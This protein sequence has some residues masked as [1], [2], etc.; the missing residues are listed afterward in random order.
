MPTDTIDSYYVSA[1]IAKHHGT[2]WTRPET[3]EF[4]HLNA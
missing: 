1:H 3:G 4:N 2:E